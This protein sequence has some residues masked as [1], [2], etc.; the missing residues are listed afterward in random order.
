MDDMIGHGKHLVRPNPGFHIEARARSAAHAKGFPALQ[1]LQRIVAT[2]Q[3][4]Q[5][6]VR[7][8]SIRGAAR[9]GQDRI[10]LGAIGHDGGA[11]RQLEAVA[12]G[13]QRACAVA[14]VAAP[15]AFRRRGGDEQL[16]LGDPALELEQP[17][18]FGRMPGQASDLDLMHGIDH[19]GRRAGAAE[20]I[21]DIGYMRETGPLAAAGDGNG[22][23]Q[24]PFLASGGECRA[25]KSRSGVGGVRVLGSD[26]RNR[27]GPFVQSAHAR[28]GRGL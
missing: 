17:G 27:F 14:D 1:R 25:G 10:G 22:D 19:G 12:I 4:H 8:Q 16:I 11:S 21:T 18:I 24:E 2:L 6:L 3:R 23:S 28:H 9:C 13:L 15:L 5:H 26:G 7:R 20:L